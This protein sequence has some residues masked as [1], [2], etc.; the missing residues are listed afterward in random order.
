[1]E[2]IFMTLQEFSDAI[3]IKNVSSGGGRNV[4]QYYLGDDWVMNAY[5]TSRGFLNPL[6]VSYLIPYV[7]KDGRYLIPEK[8]EDVS[9]DDTCI[10]GDIQK[11]DIPSGC[12]PFDCGYGDGWALTCCDDDMAM[13]AAFEMWKRHA[14][15]EG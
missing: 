11:D 4:A 3:Q 6:S 5:E 8:T 9:Y 14:N 12:K 1:M 2:G 10:F 15:R 13:S 7:L